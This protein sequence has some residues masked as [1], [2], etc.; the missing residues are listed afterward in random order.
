MGIFEIIGVIVVA[1]LAAYIALYLFYRGVADTKVDAAVPL[2]DMPA[3]KPIPIPTKKQPRFLRK[4]VVA[5]FEV[6]RWQLTENWRYKT[7]IDGKEE[8]LVIPAGFD[9]DGASIPRPFWALL[10]PTGLLLIPGLIHDYGYKYDMVWK[11]DAQGH[12]VAFCT[13]RGKEF[14]DT[15][16]RKVAQEVNQFSIVSIIAWLGVALGGKTAWNKHREANA[17]PSKSA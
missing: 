3:L 14:W 1:L 16:F 4:L 8:E 15:L 13:N 6:R 2:Q 10:S 7:T 5:I 11:L 12:C 9:F 17:K